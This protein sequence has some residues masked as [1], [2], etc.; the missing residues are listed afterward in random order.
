MCNTSDTEE[1]SNMTYFKV[2]TRKKCEIRVHTEIGVNERH[3]T[4]N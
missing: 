4:R 1:V 3:K 2:L